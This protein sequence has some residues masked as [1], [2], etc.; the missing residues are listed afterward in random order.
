MLNS[1]LRYMLDNDP[2]KTLS[3]RGYKIRTFIKPAV[4]SILK[5]S[6][7]LKL[8]V[9]KKEIVSNSRP[10]IYVASH[11]FKDD[12]LNTVLTIKDNV[13][14]VFGNL[15]LFF[16]TVDG[17][18]LWLYGCQLVDRFNKTSRNA[19][20]LKM[21]R[22][23]K[24]GGNLVV[25]AEGSWNL[26][27]NKLMED[28]H[29]GFYDVARANN[30]LVVPIVTHKVGKMCYTQMLNAVELNCLDSSDIDNI[31]YLM[32]KYYN[33]ALEMCDNKIIY[34]VIGTL[35]DFTRSNDINLISVRAKVVYKNLS[36]LKKENCYDPFYND[37][38]NYIMLL[39]NRI[40]NAQKEYEVKKIRDMMGSAKYD[41]IE[42]YPD[43][44]YM[45]NGENKYKAWD[46]YLEDTI[47]ATPYFYVEPEKE[48]L[49]KDPLI[50]DAKDVF[51]LKKVK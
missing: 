8:V 46:E 47:H 42:K 17:S 45:I 18:F 35:N 22:V 9:D 41:L 16:N 26:S 5:A 11:G 44:S 39:I 33:K 10:I 14:I 27:P 25:F 30:A 23:L 13:Y 19:M 21:D 4:F 48:A 32:K 1:A 3:V 49:F 37:K 20:K 31:L 29:W 51:C 34:S 24:L 38:L 40:V 36:L 43:Y 6:N 15:D 7:K 2:N 12:V 50:S 28:L